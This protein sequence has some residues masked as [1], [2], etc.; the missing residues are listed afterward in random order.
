MQKKYYIIATVVVLAI[1]VLLTWLF[2][3][4]SQLATTNQIVIPKNQPITHP[5]PTTNTNA[6][7]GAQIF[8]Q[9][10]NPIKKKLPDVNPVK[11]ANP[12][13]GA[14]TNPF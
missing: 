3:F 8:Q 7:L 14:Y 10:Q 13:Q 5:K 11:N 1:I 6:S 12:I 4:I 9:T 2:L